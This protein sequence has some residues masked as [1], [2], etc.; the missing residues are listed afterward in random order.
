MTTA[1]QLLAAIESRLDDILVANGYATDAGQR[2]A[3]G[4][5]REDQEA[6]LPRLAVVVVDEPIKRVDGDDHQIDADIIVEGWF[7]P[8]DGDVL[9]PGYTLVADITRALKPPGNNDQTWNDLVIDAA[10]RGRR[11]FPRDE[12]GRIGVCQ[13]RI[14]IRYIDS[15]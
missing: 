5:E 9:T 8:A 10:I 2:I 6:V 15:F 3:L 12:G 4:A 13:V 7:A 1:L 14:A 11:V